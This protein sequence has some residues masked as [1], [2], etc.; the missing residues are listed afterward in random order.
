VSRAPATFA[1][2]IGVPVIALCC[3]RDDS[4]RLH[5]KAVALP[6]P[7][8]EYESDDALIADINRQTEI[9][10]REYPDQYLWLYRRWLYRPE[11]IDAATRAKYPYYSKDV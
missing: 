2:R 4:D 9:W 7:G 8:A 5:F 6:R 10:I 3:V 11:N 1:R